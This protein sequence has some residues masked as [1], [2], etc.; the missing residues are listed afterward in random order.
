MNV[1]K[2]YYQCRFTQTSPLRVGSGEGEETDSDVM[3]DSRDVPFIPGSGVTGVLRAAFTEK[4]ADALFGPLLDGGADA[5]RDSPVL[6]SDATLPPDAQEGVDFYI[7]PRDGVGIN[8]RGSAREGAKYEFETVQCRRSYTAVIEATEAV[9]EEARA[10]LEAE[11]YRWKSDGV[12]FGAR[13]TRGYGRMKVDISRREFGPED[14]KDWLSFDPMDPSPE[15]FGGTPLQAPKNASTSVDALVIDADLQMTGPFSVRRYTARPAT[16]K[17]AFAP[18]GT[19]DALQREVATEPD[20][21]PLYDVDEKPVIPGASWAGVFRHHMRTLIQETVADDAERG[22]LSDALNLMFGVVKA[23]GEKRKSVIRFMETVVEGSGRV[24]VTRIAVDRFTNA[25]R[26]QGL[27]TST[28]ASGGHGTLRIELDA[29]FLSQEERTALL[30][31]LCFLA[32]TL[33]DLHLGLL[34]IGGEGNVGRGLCRL[35]ALRVNN[36]DVLEQA[37]Q[38]RTDYLSS[39]WNRG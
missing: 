3:T 32:A 36:S 21:E 1:W 16:Q 13:T 30:D 22:R 12:S 26:N 23:G 4:D 14:L 38:N 25:P 27:F 39:A 35:T 2:T 31:L 7:T 17:P 20:F 5:L 33:N 9:S 37:R 11:L 15:A 24:A 6:V 29:G 10:R 28:V 8:E 19:S 34:T 18:A